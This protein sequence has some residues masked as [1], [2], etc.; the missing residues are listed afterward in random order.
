[1]KAH[2]AFA[3][4]ARE[5]VLHPVAFEMGHRPVIA[6][7]GDI[8]HQ[9]PLRPLEGFDPVREATQV[10][11]NAIDLFE[12]A[13]PGLGSGRIEIRE[14]GMDGVHGGHQIDDAARAP[15]S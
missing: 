15:W 8:D 9:Y 12:E 6:D 5:V 11:R 1:M 13:R 14:H 10:G 4:P 2:P 7:D 3:W